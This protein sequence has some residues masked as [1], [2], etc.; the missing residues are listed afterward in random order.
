MQKDKV[1]KRNFDPNEDIKNAVT[2]Q[3]SV[4]IRELYY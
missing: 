4:R 2:S 1:I 3:T